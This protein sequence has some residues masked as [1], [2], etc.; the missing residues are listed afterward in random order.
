MPTPRET[1]I[2]AKL[3][4]EQYATLQALAGGQNFSAWARQVLPAA[5]SPRPTEQVLL[6]E[7]LALRAILLATQPLRCCVP[8]STRPRRT[9][10]TSIRSSS[11]HRRTTKGRLLREA[12]GLL[13]P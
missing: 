1:C 10:C 3:S 4:D 7:L 5:A 12:V 8:S 11:R 13:G 6:G 2:S 9:G